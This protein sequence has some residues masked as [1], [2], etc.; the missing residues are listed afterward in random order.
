MKSRIDKKSYDKVTEIYNA[1][2]N[3]EKVQIILSYKGLYYPTIDRRNELLALIKKQFLA[4][5][6]YSLLEQNVMRLLEKLM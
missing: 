4:D 1:S 2:S 3:Y 5:G 6:D